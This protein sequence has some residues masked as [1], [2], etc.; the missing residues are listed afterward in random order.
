MDVV[1]IILGVVVGIAVAGLFFKPFF[2]TREEF[3]DCLKFWLTPDIIS[4]FRGEYWDDWWAEAKLGLWLS[5]AALSGFATYFG[6]MQL[7]GQSG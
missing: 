5:V 7:F 2:N 4:M 3:I 1:A 6:L